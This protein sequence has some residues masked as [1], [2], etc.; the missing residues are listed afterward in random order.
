MTRADCAAGGSA[1][2]AGDVRVVDDWRDRHVCDA[3]CGRR[4]LPGETTLAM[5]CRSV[6]RH[7]SAAAAADTDLALFSSSSTC[8]SL[9]G[10]ELFLIRQATDGV[11][12]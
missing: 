2:P 1:L 4:R 8:N 6:S 11:C 7:R 12:M 3:V 5:S 9:L 10:V